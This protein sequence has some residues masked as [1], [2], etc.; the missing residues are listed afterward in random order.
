M[1]PNDTTIPQISDAE[2]TVMRIFWREGASTANEVVEAIQ[3]EENWSPNTIRTLI[4]RLHQKGALDHEKSGREFV[5]RPLVGEQECERAASRSFLSRVFNGG[6]APFLA[7]YA[8]SESLSKE[9]VAELKRILDEQ[10]GGRDDE[11]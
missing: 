11:S 1:E 6:L 7:S 5:Y 3:G 10:T 9:E 2:W 4:R 8:R